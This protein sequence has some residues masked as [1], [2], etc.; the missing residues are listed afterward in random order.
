M[1]APPSAHIPRRFLAVALAACAILLCASCAARTPFPEG[2]V[3]V[4]N[5]QDLFKSDPLVMASLLKAGINQRLREHHNEWVHF[6]AG[7][8]VIRVILLRDE[9]RTN[10]GSVMVGDSFTRT[11]TAV[12][13]IGGQEIQLQV[14]ETTRREDGVLD[15]ILG[16][17]PS[18]AQVLPPRHDRLLWL[19]AEQIADRIAGARLGPDW[20][21]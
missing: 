2:E 5:P 8:A 12:V 4:E 20:R 18:G 1:P 10:E 16:S 3:V 21:D 9:T 6:I 17:R 11:L 14:T 13:V 7:G 19:L 15:Q